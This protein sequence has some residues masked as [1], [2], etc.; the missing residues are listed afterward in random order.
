MAATRDFGGPEHVEVADDR[1]R[2]RFAQPDDRIERHHLP[3]AGPGVVLA[4][5]PGGVPEPCIGLRVDAVGAV[6]EI[7]VVDVLRAEQ[8][9]QGVRDL[10][11]RQAKAARTVA[12]DR[13]EQLRIVG[14]KAAEQAGDHARLV[15]LAH[16]L[17]GDRR[18]VR[19]V[20]ARSVE[21]FEGKPAERLQPLNGWRRDGNDERASDA[22][23]Q[24]PLQ[25]VDH[26]AS[27]SSS[28][29][30]SSYGFSRAN[31]SP[32]L[33]AAPLKLKPPTENTASTSGCFMM[34]C[35]ACFAMLIVYSSDDPDGA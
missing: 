28:F 29:C 4:Q 8:D 6:V 26:V 17:V 21:H 23:E 10:A 12:I 9:G 1:R 5:R 14:G 35:S 18:E 27:D 7:E 25:A 16:Q 31:M 30:R 11:H 20:A 2:G 22:A 34:I 15:A 13:D 33:G 24:H 19:D 32:W 3:V